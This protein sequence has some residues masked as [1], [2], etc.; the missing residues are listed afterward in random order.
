MVRNKNNL[1]SF[2]TNPFFY[3][4]LETQYLGLILLQFTFLLFIQN[5]HLFF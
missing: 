5:N 4:T 1:I 3:A 2:Y